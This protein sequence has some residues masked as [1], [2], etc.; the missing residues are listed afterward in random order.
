M[1][2]GWVAPS[3][4][5]EPLVAGIAAVG[6]AWENAGRSGR[7]RV[8]VERYFSFGAHADDV[9]EH[10]LHHYYGE[11]YLPAVRADTPTTVT[12][13]ALELERLERVGCDDMVLLPC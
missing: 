10:Y 11:A 3:F 2:E 9:A 4:G 12:H 13:L 1:G 7:P 6:S 8:V 5:M